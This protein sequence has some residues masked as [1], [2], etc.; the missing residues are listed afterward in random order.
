MI[1]N[2]Y[3]L[4]KKKI[5]FLSPEIT[6]NLYCGNTIWASVF[7]K[8]IKKKY[9][10]DITAIECLLYNIKN[11]KNVFS[12][13]IDVTFKKIFTPTNFFSTITGCFMVKTEYLLNYLFKVEKNFNYIIIR[14]IG[15]M[16]NL[17][18][19][20]DNLDY[21]IRKRIK[22]KLIYI[23]V[24]RP[25]EN[26]FLNRINNVF[27]MTFI[28]YFE[29]KKKNENIPQYII[30]PLLRN[31]NIYEK[32]YSIKNVKYDFCYVGTIH[33]RS[34]IE[35]VIEGIIGKNYKIII[36]GKI[37]RLFLDKFNF[38]KEKYKHNKNIIFNASIDGI[39]EEDG[40]DI[41]KKSKFGLRIDKPVECLS[42]K[43][44]NYI[45]YNRIPIVQR[46]KT[47]ELLLGK[48]Y[49]FYINV[50]PINI[51]NQLSNLIENITND[52]VLI[53]L[54]KVKNLKKKLNI[55]NLL[56]NNFSLEY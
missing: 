4:N 25:E 48:D 53:S 13:E 22:D 5:L 43:V 8:L 17:V 24:D 10:C 41:I 49:P 39:S 45:C 18:N 33:E 2:S 36:A 31:K 23:V 3:D 42:S 34:K 16:N 37:Q 54:D 32:N 38:L 44:L 1:K 52:N 27:H 46:I 21:S 40:N 7:L 9:N 20:L 50:N 12:D 56:K 19:I 29:D 47:H 30:P 28:R 51:K 6:W 11:K 15:L 35:D 14:S 55:D 26:K